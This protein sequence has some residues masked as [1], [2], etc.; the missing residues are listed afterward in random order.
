[1]YHNGESPSTAHPWTYL[2]HHI[3]KMWVQWPRDSSIIIHNHA[4]YNHAKS[5][6]CMLEPFESYSPWM[7][8]THAYQRFQVLGRGALNTKP[9]LRVHAQ[10]QHPSRL[11]VLSKSGSPYYSGPEFINLR[12]PP[13]PQ[14]SYT[15]SAGM[16]HN[17]ISKIY[18]HGCCLSDDQTKLN[19][20]DDNNNNNNDSLPD[21]A[22][23]FQFFLPFCFPAT[24]LSNS[25]SK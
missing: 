3:Y 13:S 25:G 6:V 12:L 18:P 8:V 5:L 20:N 1:M 9:S 15:V 21:V 10:S 19:Y 17:A 11:A 16:K 23:G 7:M 14:A 2:P 4:I 22:R 24:L